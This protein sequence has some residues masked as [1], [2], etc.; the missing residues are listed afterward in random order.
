MSRFD[1]KEDPRRRVLIQALAAGLFGSVASGRALAQG[2]GGGRPTRLPPGQS[3]YRVEGRVLVNGQAASVSTVIAANDVVET[4]PSSELVF[5]VG[6]TAMMV[7]GDSRIALKAPGPAAAMTGFE[8]LQGRVLT[9]CAPGAGRR[10]TT[11]TASISIR[12]TGFYIEA[13]AK[14]TYFCTCYGLTDVVA[15]K[16]ASSNTSVAAKHHDRPLYIVEGDQAGRNIRNAPFFNHTDYELMLIETLVGRTTPFVFA[17]S[18]Y[19]SP[20]SNSTYRN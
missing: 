5:A 12:G 18:Q 11:S 14:Q 10:I 8:V 2:V 17:G 20:R 6:D 19:D 3:I 9:V 16:D 4:G 15:R 7:R 1:E 13:E